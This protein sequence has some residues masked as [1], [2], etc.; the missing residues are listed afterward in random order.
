MPSMYLVTK[1]RKTIP[2]LIQGQGLPSVL[3]TKSQCIFR[4]GA[5]M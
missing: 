1:E 2:R 4:Q 3:C 5:I